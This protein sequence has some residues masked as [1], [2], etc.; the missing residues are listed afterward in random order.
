MKRSLLLLAV[1]FAATQTLMSQVMS[2]ASNIVANEV[3]HTSIPY[4]IDDPGTKLPPISWGLDL[5][6]IHEGNLARGVNYAGLDLIDIVRISFQTT[7]PVTDGTLAKGQKDTLDIR[8]NMLKKW[9]PSTPVNLNSD[10]AAGVIDWYHVYRSEEQANVFAP[11]WAALIAA[12]KKYVESKG[13]SVVSV[14]PFNEPDYGEGLTWGW[15]QGSKA[16]MREICRLFREDAAYAEDFKNV[17]LCGGNTL[18][19]DPAWAWYDYSKDYLD[20]G[21]TH[22]LAGSFDNYASFYEKVTADGK[23]GVGDELHNT[24]EC[25]VGV[26]YGLT[27][28][29]WWG[30]CDHTRSQFMKAERGTRLAYAENRGR[31]TAA[32]VYRHPESYKEGC[33]VQGFVGTSERQA[34]KTT[35]RFASLDRDVFYNGIGPTREYIVTTPGWPNGAGYDSEQEH[36][37]TNAEGLVN[38]QGGDDIMPALPT[39]PA[40]YKIMNRASGHLLAPNTNSLTPGTVMTQQKATTSQ[41]QRWI[42]TPDSTNVG[43]DFTYFRFDNVKNPRLRPDVENWSLL[44]GGRLILWENTAPGDNEK[45]YFEYAGDGW[46]YIRSKHSALCMQVTPGTATQVTRSGR[47]VIQGKFTGD[48]TQQWRLVP[49]DVTT[50]MVAP[51]PPADVDATPLPAGVLLTWTAPEDKDANEYIV[52]R[53][54]DGNHWFTIHNNV[55]GNAYIDNTVDPSTTYTYRVQTVDKSLNRSAASA[56]VVCKA[57][58]EHA[59]IMQISGD[60]LVDT[61]PHGNHAAILGKLSQGTGKVGKS[62]QLSSTTAKFAQLPSTIANHRELT[63]ATWVDFRS[64]SNWQRVFDFGSDTDH[65]VFL[66]YKNSDNSKPRLAIK[67]GGAEQRLDLPSAFTTKKWYHVAV[68]F[69]GNAVTVYVNGEAVATSTEMN[70]R[71]ADFN[72]A[73]NYIGRSQFTSDPLMSAYIDDFRVYN[74]ALSAAEVKAIAELA[75]GIEEVNNERMKSEKSIYDLSGRQIVNRKSLNSKL[76]RGVYIINGKK[77]LIH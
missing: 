55:V 11:R 18:N 29:I 7:H 4:R 41:A 60:S 48:F 57:T 16:E 38:I 23:V 14:S 77:V 36:H 56:T 28:G 69:A 68:T 40:V 32:A 45:W 43:G 52:Q 24:M 58:N 70:I 59:C 50:D 62:L 9:A 64:T 61:T 37:C 10:Q 35:F 13:V 54:I 42:I 71:P 26:E 49:A 73:F 5:A 65:Y 25:M 33:D 2:G 31:W 19:C 6:W 22:Q 72:P 1:C 27:K 44:D 3:P 12:T 47:T 75:D 46:F 21:N 30:T 15:H 34:G 8:L 63:I 39:Q 17:K 53:S 74:Y 66:T 20:E 76:P 67:N 51:Q